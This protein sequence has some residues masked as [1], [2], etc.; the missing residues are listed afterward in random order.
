MF[1]VFSGD[2]DFSGRRVGHGQRHPR[3]VPFRHREVQHR[4]RPTPRAL[5][6]IASNA[7]P[8]ILTPKSLGDNRQIVG[9]VGPRGVLNGVL[10][11]FMPQTTGS[12]N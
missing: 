3:R 9:F 6:C 2:D 5:R 4:R 11:V 12:G 7:T 8:G 10:D 1:V